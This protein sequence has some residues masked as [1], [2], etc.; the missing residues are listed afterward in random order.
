MPRALIHL[1]RMDRAELNRLSGIIIDAALCVHRR[2]GP[3][4][5]ESVYVA[6]LAQE[7]ENRGLKVQREVVI[8]FSFGE[9]SF[10]R[11]FRADL[12]VE[13]AII[14]E[15]KSKRQILP[16]HLKQLLTYLRALD[17]RLGLLLNFGAPLM[18]EGI[19][20]VVNDF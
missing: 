15:I 20:R 7:L 8:P 10:K 3:G 18:K 17:K 4:L 14:L 11:G 1:T 2:I 5:S 6:V 13:D 9:L 12:I 19:K 16:E